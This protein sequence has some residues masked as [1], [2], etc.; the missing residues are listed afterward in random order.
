MP[1]VMFK[2]ASPLRKSFLPSAQSG[3]F[4][5]STKMRIEIEEAGEEQEGRKRMIN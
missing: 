3:T 4:L 5:L 1:V 2:K